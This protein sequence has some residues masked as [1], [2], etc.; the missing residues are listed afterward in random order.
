M[1]KKPSIKT[2]K[3]WFIKGE[4]IKKEKAT[5]RGIFSSRKLRKRGMDEQEQKGV[6]APKK[7]ADK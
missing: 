4:V 7:E 5:P 3:Y 1:P 6:T 2:I